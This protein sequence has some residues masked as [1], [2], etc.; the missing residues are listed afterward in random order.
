MIPVNNQSGAGAAWL[1]WSVRSL[2]A[3]QIWLAGSSFIGRCPVSVSSGNFWWKILN[4][5]FW[6][7]NLVLKIL[8]RNLG[9][10]VFSGI[11]L[12][13]NFCAQLGR[14]F[15]GVNTISVFVCMVVF[16]YALSLPSHDLKSFP[17]FQNRPKYRNYILFTRL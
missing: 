9:W 4:G 5:K 17:A 8:V 7:A 16:V 2:K 6:V 14:N 3:Q 12:V 10:K 1:E 13:D 11:F 15:F